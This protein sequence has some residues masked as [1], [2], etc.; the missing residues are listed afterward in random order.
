MIRTAGL[1][2]HR[3]TYGILQQALQ[4]RS[5]QRDSADVF[6]PSEDS[7]PEAALAILTKGALKVDVNVVVDV[8]KRTL[9]HIASSEGNK[10][11]VEK[12]IERG[13]VVDAVDNEGET[14]L[15]AAVYGGHEEV[16]KVL[17]K[18]G[19]DVNKE[20]IDGDTPLNFAIWGQH[21]EIVEALLKAGANA[22]AEL[23]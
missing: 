1:Y 11:V 3:S 4:G 17:L 16:V 14:P 23:V 22:L 5:L 13:A 15:Y 20:N 10:D 7:N 8:D 12:L 18:A 19:A 6:Y 21:N 2:T 9:L